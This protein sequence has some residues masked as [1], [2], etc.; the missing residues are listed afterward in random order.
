MSARRFTLI[1]IIAVTVIILAVSTVAVG[2]LHEP[3]TAFAVQSAADDFA[4]FCAGAR[5]RAMERGCDIAV[6]FT[7]EDNCFDARE[8]RTPPVRCVLDRP[9]DDT[10]AAGAPD[11]PLFSWQLPEK[12]VTDLALP[13]NTGYRTGEFEVIRFF[14]DGGAT[15]TAPFHIAFDG[16][17]KRI[18]VSPLCGTV[19][20]YDEQ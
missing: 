7:P 17:S 9:A 14:P 11:D 19:T 18:G 20:V 13:E 2:T 6:V 15:G 1:E 12:F 5:M 16:A 8:S 10:A 3:P 4:L